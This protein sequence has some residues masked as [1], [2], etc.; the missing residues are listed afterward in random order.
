VGRII[1]K[2]L[3]KLIGGPRDGDYI[4]TSPANFSEIASDV[5]SENGIITGFAVYS[6]TERGDYKFDRIYK[7]HEIMLIPASKL[8][9]IT[10]ER[11]KP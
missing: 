6:K 10:N 9:M 5:A 11:S 1:R 2:S 3:A 8:G 4:E 7:P